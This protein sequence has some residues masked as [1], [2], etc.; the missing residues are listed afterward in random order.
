MR[1]GLKEKS[2]SKKIIFIV[3]LLIVAIIIG[4]I[5]NM[6]LTVKRYDRLILPG[7]KIGNL[8]LGG[9]TKVEAE[10]LLNEKHNFAIKNNKITIK[11]NKKDYE[12]KYSKLGLKYDAKG[13]IDEVYDYGS[14]KNIF[15]KYKIIKKSESKVFTPK[16]TYNLE[17]IK[18]TISNIEKDV[19]KEAK[20]ATISV[21]SS[22]DIK[23]LPGQLGEKLVANKLENQIK[24]NINKYNGNSF[25]LKAPIETEKPK[26]TEDKLKSVDS[27]IASA[28]TSYRSSSYERATNV[29]LATESID[30]TVLM[31]GDVFSFNEVV[32]ERTADKGYRP[33]GVIV[34][35]KL[36]SGLGGGVCQVSS[37]LYNAVLKSG[38]S[39]VER[40]H[41]SFPSSYVSFGMDA[42][43]DYGSLDY[44]FK[45]TF[46]YPIYIKAY[47]G[48]RVVSF[49][50]YSNKNL[51]NRTYKLQNSIYATLTPKTQYIN[52]STLEEGKT[53]QI[54][55]AHTGYKVKVYRNIYENGVLLK[56]ELIS[57]DFYRPVN[58]LIKRGT[59]KKSTIEIDKNKNKTQDKDLKEKPK[60]SEKVNNNTNS[61]IN[62]K[63]NNKTNNK[64]NKS[65]LSENAKPKNQ[66]TNIK[67][68]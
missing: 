52:D 66:H 53:E 23:I 54:Q 39:S 7:M 17:I 20:N 6:Y 9:K 1:K 21:T 64:T 44:K 51:K 24:S 22:G 3:S 41:H 47:A 4:F 42:T 59:K 32:G 8:D 18:E 33:A 50:I 30:G 45:N 49:N 60:K 56:K 34:G 16:F 61:K 14:K 15:K 55:G 27:L 29:R 65:T 57:D 40:A 12:I 26:V 63:T 11:T 25:Q 35:N 28:S 2:A 48:G 36:E 58:A 62:D 13:I 37:T 31:P 43:V 46:E 68:N 10:K 67:K 5:T 19:N 38:L